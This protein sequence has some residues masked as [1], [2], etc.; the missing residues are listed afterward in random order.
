MSRRERTLPYPDTEAF[1][2]TLSADAVVGLC[3]IGDRD[4]TRQDVADR[5]AR[6]AKTPNFPTLTPRRSP[7]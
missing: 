1:W 7:R 4:L 2:V 6:D 5:A 3:A